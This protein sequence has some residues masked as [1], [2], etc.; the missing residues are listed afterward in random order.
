M[1]LS[2]FR[3]ICP[4]L[5]Y[6]LYIYSCC[7]NV[8]VHFFSFTVFAPG[9]GHI[10]HKP[11]ELSPC[12]LFVP[13]LKTLDTLPFDSVCVHACMRDTICHFNYLALDPALHAM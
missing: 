1:L 4:K 3:D 12:C 5:Y 8:F 11:L 10:N 9:G 13:T 6:W 2:L 7:V